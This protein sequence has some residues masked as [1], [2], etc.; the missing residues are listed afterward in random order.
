MAPGASGND[1]RRAVE[2]ANHAVL[3]DKNSVYLQFLAGLT[4]YRQGKYAETSPILAEAAERLPNRAGPRLV[5]AMAQFKTGAAA[6]ARKTL[7]VAVRKPYWFPAQANHTTTSVNH[8]L[9]REAE[10][11]ILPDLPAFLKGKYQPQDDD[12]RL[13]LVGICE[14]KGRNGTA[15]GLFGDLFSF[16]PGM[17]D[18][19]TSDCNN[20]A[21]KEQGDDQTEVLNSETRY[22]AVRSAALAGCGVGEDRLQFDAAHRTRWRNQARIWLEADFPHWMD[23]LQSSDQSYRELAAKMLKLRQVDPDLAG[24]RD[25]NAISKLP[26]SEQIPWL[27][28]WTKLDAA[29]ATHV[30]RK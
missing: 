27:D 4:L 23:T 29:L 3:V 21:L 19:L 20:R 13:A 1:L 10:A 30:D 22:V 6:K 11:T 16:N 24:I 28:F 25:Q 8:V 26:A 2:L 5:L 7:A 12:E 15:A 18:D 17:A 14:S 9:R